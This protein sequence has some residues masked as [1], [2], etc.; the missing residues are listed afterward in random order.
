MSQ[1]AERFESAVDALVADGPVKNRLV[2]AYVDYLQD[3]QHVDLPIAGKRQFSELHAALHRAQAVGK[4]DCVR[5][6][7][8]KMSADEAGR[9]AR[10]IVRLYIELLAMEQGARAQPE[11]A[12]RVAEDLPPRF[13]S[14]S[15]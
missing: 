2:T 7:V 10:I 8:Q 1:I 14:G 5:A 9:L 3:L 13:L 11:K 4:I 6:S 15:R 12:L